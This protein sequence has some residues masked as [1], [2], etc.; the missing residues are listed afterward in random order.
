MISSQEFEEYAKAHNLC[1][2]TKEQSDQYEETIRDARYYRSLCRDYE[3]VIC[4]L[5]EAKEKSEEKE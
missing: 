4:K 1:V 5:T 2:W 3:K